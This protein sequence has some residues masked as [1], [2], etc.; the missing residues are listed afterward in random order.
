MVT[1]RPVAT[2][3]LASGVPAWS[4]QGPVG[5]SVACSPMSVAVQVSPPSMLLMTPVARSGKFVPDPYTTRSLTTLRPQ[6]ADGAS[7]GRLFT[8]VQ[9]APPSLV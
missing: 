6:I 1:G 9:V 7:G 3:A 4:V 8:S 5:G 2:L